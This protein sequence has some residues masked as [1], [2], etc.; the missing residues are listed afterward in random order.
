MGRGLAIFAM[1]LLLA[2]SAERAAPELACLVVGACSEDS[3]GVPAAGGAGLV[4]GRPRY[5]VRGVCAYE[6]NESL[7]REAC[8]AGSAGRT[9]DGQVP[10]ACVDYGAYQARSTELGREQAL[11]PSLAFQS[12]EYARRYL[13]SVDP[14]YTAARIQ[15]DACHWWDTMDSSVT[16]FI[17]GD[18]TQAPAEGDLLI[19]RSVAP[20]TSQVLPCRDAP[21]HIAVIAQVD[22]TLRLVHLGE[23]NLS[24]AAPRVLPLR[25]EPAGASQRFTIDAPG[26]Q[27]W[28]RTSSTPSD[29]CGAALLTHD[30]PASAPHPADEPARFA[31][32]VGCAAGLFCQVDAGRCAPLIAGADGCAKAPAQ[33]TG[34]TRCDGSR[35]VCDDNQR[36]SGERF[37]FATARSTLCFRPGPYLPARDGCSVTLG[38]KDDREAVPALYVRDMD[39]SG[40][41]ILAPRLDL[42]A[43]PGFGFSVVASCQGGA[44]GTSAMGLRLRLAVDQPTPDFALLGYTLPQRLLRCDGAAQ[45]LQF[46]LREGFVPSGARLGWLRLDP[47]LADAGSASRT[48]LFLRSIEY[49]ALA[50]PMACS[51]G[52]K[53]GDESD[54]DCG[55]D[56]CPGC[57]G[58]FRCTSSADCRS[59][60]CT[61][62]L[63]I[64]AGPCSGGPVPRISWVP[65]APLVTA[66]GVVDGDRGAVSTVLNDEIH[67]FG[68]KAYQ[69]HRVFNPALNRWTE[70]LPVPYPIDEGVAVTVGG[71][72]YAFSV[73]AGAYAL[74]YEPATDRWIQKAQ[75]PWPRG[76]AAPGVLGGRVYMAGGNSIHSGRLT[77]Y[78]IASDSFLDLAPVVPPSAMMASVMYQGKLHV[79]GGLSR[80]Y[81]AQVY[82][83]ASDQWAPLQDN[84]RRCG[85]HALARGSVIWLL[86]G[87]IADQVSDSL[88]FYDPGAGRWCEGPILPEPLSQFAA[89]QVGGKIYLL[90]GE[91]RSTPSSRVW[92]GTVDPY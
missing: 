85:A 54:L 26:V 24:A 39:P 83:P 35:C 55:G 51:D 15:G 77:A 3:P 58:G 25:A 56:Q 49:R 44:T 2:C 9:T 89:E 23:Q 17:N 75:N 81:Q 74:R 16:R 71:T 47:L 19:F 42:T 52:Q 62:G 87:G 21:G 12:V 41:Q 57:A 10:W 78:D 91:T 76:L 90:G 50:P 40:A 45:T 80:C 22:L 66:A 48:E 60:Q 53:N 69:R 13:T 67:L 86:G 43:A 30:H 31:R 72:L 88:F 14:A 92:E 70:K 29:Q 28:L 6:N 84:V 8:A 5:A 33:C 79:F 68:G 64:E 18:A 27:G 4:W 73:D 61:S 34:G 65:R 82:D 59:G 63:C 36:V 37:S 20:D 38:I 46:P 1:M 7:T 11:R 32:L